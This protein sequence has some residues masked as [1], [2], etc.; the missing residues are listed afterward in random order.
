MADGK[1]IEEKTREI[2]LANSD[3]TDLLVND[4]QGDL[5]L[6]LG[7]TSPIGIRY[8]CVHITWQSMASEEKITAER[9]MLTFI[10]SQDKDSEEKYSVFIAIRDQLKKMMN[11]NLGEPLTEID[12]GLNEGLRVVMILKTLAEFDFSDEM[13]KFM[14]IVQFS[15]V[16][17]EDEDFTTD[18]GTWICS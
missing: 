2:L 1:P 12:V 9:G 8:P 7:R 10:I 4:A 15:I 17:G 13:D 5:T 16:K 18:Y 6:Y 11:R 14:S 3:F